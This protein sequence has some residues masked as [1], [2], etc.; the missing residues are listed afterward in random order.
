VLVPR[1]DSVG[2]RENEK[3]GTRSGM[4]LAGSPSLVEGTYT[5]PSYIEG[6]FRSAF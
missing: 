6:K 2:M 1:N 5:R 3:I 4:E